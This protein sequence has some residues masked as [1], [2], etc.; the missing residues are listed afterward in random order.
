M[1]TSPDPFNTAYATLMPLLGE[2]V[3]GALNGPKENA[4]KLREAIDDALDQRIGKLERMLALT[5]ADPANPD[6]VARRLLHTGEV[7]RLRT[8]HN[9]LPHLDEHALR[10]VLGNVEVDGRLP[11]YV[12]P[13]PLTLTH[14][15]MGPA[16]D[17]RSPEERIEQAVAWAL[18][19]VRG[20]PPGETL[21]VFVPRP[22]VAAAATAIESLKPLEVGVLH[23]V[24]VT[25]VPNTK[26]AAD[27]WEISDLLIVTPA[28]RST[29]PGPCPA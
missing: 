17:W 2:L 7:T 28:R 12:Q 15:G 19:T 18:T 20:A 27:P 14:P 26:A 24:Q 23:G 4:R 21:V 5:A 29:P 16:C 6:A 10:Y 11:D 3:I 9:L 22:A 8:Y 13:R 25:T 1:D